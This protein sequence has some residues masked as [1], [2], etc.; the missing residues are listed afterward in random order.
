MAVYF[1]VVWFQ[2]SG[3]RFQIFRFFDPDTYHLKKRA[4]EPRFVD[5]QQPALSNAF[6]LHPK[7]YP[8]A[9]GSRYILHEEAYNIK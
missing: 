6:D 1:T 8:V 4:S 7:Q 5:R 2:I 9:R 3:V